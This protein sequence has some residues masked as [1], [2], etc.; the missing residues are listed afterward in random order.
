MPAGLHLYTA[1]PIVSSSPGLSDPVP[2]LPCLLDLFPLCVLPIYTLCSLL[3]CVVPIPH[4]FLLS[5]R[6]TSRLHSSRPQVGRGPLSF[7]TRISGLSVAS[8]LVSLLLRLVPFK[9]AFSPN[10]RATSLRN[11]PSLPTYD[12]DR[13][14]QNDHRPPPTLDNLPHW[15]CSLRRYLP[16]RRSP[17]STRS[18]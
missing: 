5:F 3:L 1:T 9:S 16:S 15:N 17:C 10:P 12:L 14:C 2:V 11:C 8:G 6:C 13:P 7:V 18:G 4:C